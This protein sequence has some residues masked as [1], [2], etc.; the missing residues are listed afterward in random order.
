M[1]ITLFTSNNSR[2]LYLSNLLSQ[3]CNKLY[4][5]QE[6]KNLQLNQPIKKNNTANIFNQYFNFVDIAEKKIFNDK[7][8]KVPTKNLQLLSILYGKINDL[9]LNNINHFLKSEIYIVFGASYIKAG[10]AE[11]LINKR[12]INIHAGVSPYYRGTDCNFWALYDNNPHLVGT[13]VHLLSKGLDNGGILYHAMSMLNSNPFEYTMST[14]KSAF[15][16]LV[17]KIL[18]KSIFKIN[19]VVQNK[20]K[21]IR[22]TKKENFNEKVIY[23]F[24]KKK[25][26][27]DKIKFNHSLLVNPFFFN[28]KL[29]KNLHYDN[30][31]KY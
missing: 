6:C 4:V 2:H 16:S 25:I 13:T 19:P 8:I 28:P 23:E 31:K 18:D 30:I 3:I 17:E 20:N 15:H 5:V 26:N 29:I 21:E 24:F 9:N 22:Y 12:A 27:L 1:N 7:Y 10:L 11:F 14:L